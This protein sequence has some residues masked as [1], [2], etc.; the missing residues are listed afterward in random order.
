MCSFGL[1]STRKM[2]TYWRE[3]NGGPLRWSSGAHD[4]QRESEKLGCF[5]LKKEWFGGGFL[6]SVFSYLIGG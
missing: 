3:S 1:P 4:I 6:V 5:V 2:R